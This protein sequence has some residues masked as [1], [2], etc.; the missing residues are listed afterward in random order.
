V[1]LKKPIASG[2][3][4]Q[5]LALLEWARENGVSVGAV[6][7]GAVHVELTGATQRMPERSVED[8]RMAIYKQMGGPA[9]EYAVDAGIPSGELQPVVGRR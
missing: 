6:T 9:F 1:S 2:D 4:E 7:V 8:D 3:T 5:V